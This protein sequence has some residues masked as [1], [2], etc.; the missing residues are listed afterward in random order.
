[1]AGSGVQKVGSKGVTL[2]FSR[3]VISCGRLSNHA[4]LRGP[5]QH[6]ALGP[7]A[8]YIT[9]KS[10]SLFGKFLFLF[11]KFCLEFQKW[12]LL[13]KKCCSFLEKFCSIFKKKLGASFGKVLFLFW[14]VLFRIPKKWFLLL[15]KFVSFWLEIFLFRIPVRIPVSYTYTPFV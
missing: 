6:W 2:V 8:R 9:T 15:K 14:K 7:R 11:E 3:R 4:M 13:L 1:M 5:L 10:C 12:L